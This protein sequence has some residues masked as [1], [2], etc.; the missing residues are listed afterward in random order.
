MEDLEG[1]ALEH[2]PRGR[3]PLDSRLFK[4]VEGGRGSSLYRLFTSCLADTPRRACERGSITLETFCGSGRTL[5]AGGSFFLYEKSVLRESDCL[6]GR[7][8]EVC[9]DPNT[10]FSA[11]KKALKIMGI[12]GES[13]PDA[14]FHDAPRRREAEP[15][16][17]ALPNTQRA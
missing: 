4:G 13:L 12:Q 3:V 9:T 16:G 7:R 1:A 15:R 17:L 10:P 11:S 2:L 6:R 5:H 14:S 8:E